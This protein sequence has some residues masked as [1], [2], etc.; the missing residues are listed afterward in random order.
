MA[1]SRWTLIMSLT[2]ALGAAC[3]EAPPPSRPPPAVSGD[4]SGSRAF[5][6]LEQLVSIGPRV[7]GSE[8]ADAA[9]S[10]LR[11]E[12]E[13]AGIEVTEQSVELELPGTDR[14][15]AYRNLVGV[16]PGSS[17]DLVVL[18]APFDSQPF[19]SFR[20]V[21]ANDGASGAAL[22]LELGRVLTGRPLPYT[23]WLALSSSAR[24]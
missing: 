7:S 22:L 19:E 14:T 18:A 5:N 6:H 2:G 8:G 21:G 4:F 11:A 24:K 15:V 9:R 16:L 10:Y 17:E 20:F 3:A 1:R 23:V 13:R 12:L